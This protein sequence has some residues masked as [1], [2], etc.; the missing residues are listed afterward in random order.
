MYTAKKLGR[1]NMQFF[2]PQIQ[3][4]LEYKANLSSHLRVALKEKQF[5]LH[6]QPQL[7]EQNQVT[8]AEALIRWSHPE[9]GFVSPG[10]FIP[11]AEETAFIIKLG[12]WVLEEGCK[13]L[14][15]WSKDSSLKELTLSVNVSAKQFKDTRFVDI[16]DALCHKWEINPSKLKLE[17]T[18]SFLVEHIQENIATMNALKEKGIYLSM[19]DFGTGYSSLSYL[20][21]LPLDQL[22][23]DRTFVKDIQADEQGE[24]IVKTII[25]M[26]NN[27]K[28][29]VIAEGVETKP[30]KDFLLANGCSCY[31]GYYFSKPVSREKFEEYALKQNA[32][33]VSNRST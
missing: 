10:E 23:I 2:N 20:R 17:I 31:Q 12:T 1:N 26:A 6:Y 7:N 32:V 11:I 30:Q 21:N 22:K 18:E 5:Y 24:L 33:T 28:M 13:L 8:G 29:N 19:D 27:L 14:H 3:D 15:E 16:V 4:E 25:G 9:L